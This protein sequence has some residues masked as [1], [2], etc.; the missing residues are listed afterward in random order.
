MFLINSQS[1]VSIAI[2]QALKGWNIAIIGFVAI[3]LLII[4]RIIQKVYQDLSFSASA[5]EETTTDIKDTLSNLKIIR[6]L[7]TYSALIIP[8]AYFTYCYII[9]AGWESHAMEWMNLIIR[10]AHMIL[11]IA[12]IG[13]SFYFIFLENSINRTDG[14]RDELAGNLWAIHG[15]GFYYLEKYKVSPAELPKKLH[16]FKYEAYYTWVTGILLLCI[17]YY[18]NAKAF[19]IDKSVMDIQPSTGIAIGLSTLVVGWVVYDL[20]CK[21]ALIEKQ[22]LFIT[23]LFVFVTAVSWGLCQV[24]NSRAAYIHVGA[25]LGTIMVANV[26]FVIIPSQ[27]QLVKAAT[28]GRTPDASLGKKA[29]L[30]SLHNNYFTLPVLFIMISN[31]FPSTF[32]NQFNWAILIALSLGSILVK[33]YWNLSEK[34]QHPVWMIYGA[35][36]IAI[37]LFVV[38]APKNN[39]VDLSQPI[40]F[41]QVQGIIQQRCLTCHSAHPTD[42]EWTTAPNGVMFDTPD[43]IVNMVDK[44]KSRA[45][46]TQSMPQANKT[47]MTQQERDI[48][49]AWIA[50]GAKLK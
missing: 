29:G 25:M 26:F 16:W 43:K 19:L 23:I 37:I 38:T 33:H 13:A 34:G 28:E 7:L 10:W 15:G 24:F 18:M 44:I 6:S 36:I 12:W 41:T 42:D 1:T 8:L 14:L 40:L 4:A 32:G 45:I 50:Q 9:A 11:G 31:H 5:G 27:K 2:T 35:I 20:L 49:A 21:S 17:V 30:R 22:K 48:I 47:G 46:D 3:S 39:K